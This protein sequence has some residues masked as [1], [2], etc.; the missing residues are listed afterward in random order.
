MDTTCATKKEEWEESVAMRAQELVAIAETIKILNDDDA[1]ELFKKT[2][3]S[4]ASLVQVFDGSAHVAQKAAAL[5]KQVQARMSKDDHVGV[6]LITMALT[7]KKVNFDKVI[8]LIDKLVATL[9]EE[10]LDDEHKKEYCNKQLDFT[11]DKVKGLKQTTEDLEVLIEDTKEKVA[12]L[13]DDL[14]ALAEGLA[15]LDKE[16][17]EQTATRQEE[18]GDFSELMASNSAAKEL[19]G[20]AKNRLNKFYNPKLYKAPPK[21]VLSEEERITVNMGGTLAPTAPPGGIA[22]TGVTAFVQVGFHHQREAPPPPPEAVAAYSKKNQMNSGVIAMIDLLIA[23]LDKE[24]TEAEVTEKDAQAE[25][26]SF[27]KDAA[28]KRVTDSKTITDKEEAKANGEAALLKAKE[29]S[30]SKM[31]ELM[32]T[33][34][35]MSSLHA[36]CDWLLSNFDLRREARAGE[37]ESLQKAKA[38]L[39]G[40]DFSLM[41]TTKTG[42]AKALRGGF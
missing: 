19:L 28:T 22:G 5:V 31:K 17:T 12:T 25:Y 3:P 36:E 16:V 26:E 27:M 35:Y 30:T 37:V 40:A 4:S 29:E 14:K 10:Q 18:H 13:K 21:R 23:D 9:K 1:L 34:G 24:M 15:A 8:G 33:E 20:V 39:A 32:A 38:V 42:Q 6:D 41:Q 11:E 7:G 2:L